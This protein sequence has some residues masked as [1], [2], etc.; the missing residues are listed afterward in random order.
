[1]DILTRIDDAV[2]TL[3]ETRRLLALPTA[4]IPT[5]VRASDNLLSILEQ[6]K[7]GAVLVLDMDFNQ[8]LDYW[9]TTKPV[10]LQAA[11]DP[12]PGRISQFKPL[13]TIRGFATLG[14]NTTLRAI[15]CEG[16]IPEGTVIT[17]GPSTALDR[18]IVYGSPKGQHRGIAGNNTDLSIDN[19]HIGN[20]WKD[21]DTQA[22]GGWTNA[23]RHRIWNTYLESSGENICYGGS[24][25]ITAA[26]SPEDIDIFNCDIVKPLAWRGR[27]DMTVKNLFEL[28]NAKNVRLRSCRLDNSWAQGQTGYA[29]LLSI[30]NQDGSGNPIQ[31]NP[32]ATVEDV[33]IEDC[34]M[35]HLGAG[36]KITGHDDG[37]IS[38]SM[39]NVM[40][41]RNTF[42]DI[43][44]V[45]Y[46]TLNPDGSTTYGDG[47]QLLLQMGC[48]NLALENNRWSGRNFNTF[49]T[50]GPPDRKYV[51]FRYVDN[52]AYEGDYGIHGEASPGLGKLA[53]DFYAPT[54]YVWERNTVIK[55]QRPTS[56]I[57]Y[58]NGTTV[59][60]AA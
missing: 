17:A 8:S 49:I 42:E 40:V 50:F 26:L 21:Q 56:D 14:P 32:W 2:A 11:V 53:L 51:N 37:Q 4:T 39:K 23:K 60:K 22:V 1:M 6:A 28:K 34:I 10:T 27:T 3:A 47:R 12:G 36:L 41:R 35:R 43:D 38:G 46:S 48:E 15:R 13:P 59:I 55:A 57:V 58:P 54:G 19:S 33:L 5:R 9:T 25:S 44:A 45:A 18:V 20:I 52:S 30:R 16:H 7:A 29:I 24:D 31:R